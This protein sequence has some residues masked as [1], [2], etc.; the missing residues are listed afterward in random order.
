[1]AQITMRQAISDALRV[2]LSTFGVR[3]IAVEP[4]SIDTEI[5][6]KG[7]RRDQA[8]SSQ[9]DAALRE[10]YSPLQRLLEKLNRNPRGISPT[11]VATVI[12]DAL[13]ARNPHNRYLVGTDARSLALLRYL[14]EGLRDRLI[15][16]RVWRD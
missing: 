8:S 4:G 12:G 10:L 1:M 5:W 14:P 2:E 7:A 15:G 13:T 9:S 11:A 3:V 6:S 16:T